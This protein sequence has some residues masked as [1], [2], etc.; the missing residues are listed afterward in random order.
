MKFDVVVIGAGPGG[1]TGAIR[2][3]QLGMKTA[4][5]ELDPNLGGTCLLRGCIPTKALL[6]SA[7][8]H[9]SIRQAGD[10]GL[11]VGDVQVDFPAVQ[12]RKAGV[13]ERLA[14]GVA[15]L[16]KKNGI[17]VFEGTGRIEG[18][19]RVA[20]LSRSG[21]SQ[22]LEAKNVLLATG[23]EAKGLPGI[24]PDGKRILTSDQILELTAVPKT[25]LIL[26]AGAVGVEFASIYASFGS[27]VTLVELLPRIV[28][29][30]DE[31]VS[32]ELERCFR[33]R[34]IEIVTHARVE[35]AATT[36]RGVEISLT[37][38]N[39]AGKS[40][41]LSAE[42][43]LLGVGRR[44]KSEPLGLGKTRVIVEKGF[45]R[46]DTEYRTAEPGIWAVG[47]LVGKAPLAHVASH[48][49]VAAVE[50]MAGQKPHPIN[51][52]HVPW[53]TYCEP[54][55]ARVGLTETQARER[56]FDVKT[57][58][59]PFTALGRALILGEN[60]GFVKLVTDAKYGE[61]L[62]VHIIG[63]R[64]TE[65]IAEGAALLRLEAVNEEILAIVHAHPTLSEAVGEAALDVL[66]RS[67]NR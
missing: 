1:Y 65:L 9:H 66:G 37:A 49:A 10:F 40:R 48:E 52:D 26:G 43:L 22:I 60:E 36:P 47:D 18:P 46:T 63:P 2:A 13:V 54:E 20:V 38:G 12:K 41:S 56:G 32:K 31:E 4:I 25:L 64:A 42:L 27:K 51:Y 3:A 58:K 34:G 67:L 35:K 16:M 28:P 55:V 15:F 7:A 5:V 45:V 23:S 33:K 50:A 11:R 39:D 30:E 59:F 44:P 53:C 17:Q 57:G 61:V 29:G 14:K 21:K 6:Q 19:G 8:L 24:E 62:G